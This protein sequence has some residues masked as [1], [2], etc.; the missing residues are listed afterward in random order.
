MVLDG[1]YEDIRKL[2][3]KFEM[4]KAQCRHILNQV[5]PCHAFFENLAIARP[6][7]SLQKLKAKIESSNQPNVSIFAKIEKDIRNSRVSVTLDSKLGAII[8]DSNSWSYTLTALANKLLP[9][10]ATAKPPWKRL[11]SRLGYT[12]DHIT[13]FTVKN[14]VDKSS[15]ERLISV[16]FSDS[17]SLSPLAFAEKLEEIQRNDAANIVKDW[18]KK[19]M[20]CQN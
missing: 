13:A 2:C 18:A 11:A 7:L 14:E 3:S 1:S 20:V 9:E 16:L 17:P 8:D 19:A 15:T 5:P 10:T 6:Q 12:N 4:T